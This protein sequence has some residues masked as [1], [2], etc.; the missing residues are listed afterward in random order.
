M[1]LSRRMHRWIV[2][3]L[4]HAIF[5]MAVSSTNVLA[6]SEYAGNRSSN[7]GSITFEVF[8]IRPSAEG[9]VDGRPTITPDGLTVTA[10]LFTLIEMAYNPMPPRYWDRKSVLHFPSW[11]SEQMYSIDA[12]VASEDAEAWQAQG[13][14]LTDISR[15]ALQAALKGRC[16]L[17]VK[18]TQTEVPYIEL[19][20]G[21]DGAKLTES[22]PYD[23]T[24]IRG[25]SVLGKGFYYD[26]GG[27]RNYVGVSMKEFA[28][29]LMRISPGNL[30]QD[31]TGLDGRYDF[32]LP[33][34]DA[35]DPSDNL[36]SSPLD[37]VPIKDIGLTLRPGKG[38]SFILDVESVSRPDPN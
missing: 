20:V 4:T 23:V 25:G 35:T 3:L 14:N 8:S 30:I 6:Q 2:T 10:T 29:Y 36:T 18:V 13:N 9:A 19:V 38:P 27:K 31:K 11:A 1:P 5:G 26:A 16:N 21:K 34:N 17:R 28:Q 22:R 37:R 33:L 7:T 15:G 12:R 24:Q 32:V